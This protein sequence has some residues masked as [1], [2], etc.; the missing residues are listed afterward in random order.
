[1]QKSESGSP[2]R[3]HSREVTMVWVLVLVIGSG[4][5]PG[6][7]EAAGGHIEKIVYYTTEQD[8]E[9]EAEKFRK[10]IS[11]PRVPLAFCVA[12][13]SPTHIIGR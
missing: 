1:V 13:P 11:G 8:C 7:V 5:A 12:A 3:L 4:A 2:T 10:L 9:T 6:G